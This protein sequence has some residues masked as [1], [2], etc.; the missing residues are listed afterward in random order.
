MGRETWRGPVTWPRKG[1]QRDWAPQIVGPGRG[2]GTCMGA[3]GFAFWLH[4]FVWGG[5]QWPGG[6]SPQCLIRVAEA[7]EWC[8]MGRCPR[9]KDRLAP[10]SGCMGGGGGACFLESLHLV[11]AGKQARPGMRVHSLVL[12]PGVGA[13]WPRSRGGAGCRQCLGRPGA[14]APTAVAGLAGCPCLV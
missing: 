11:P 14:P 13:R 4:G 7:P 2:M 1:G 10:W 5:W 12:A 3:D 8:W 6:S 9:R